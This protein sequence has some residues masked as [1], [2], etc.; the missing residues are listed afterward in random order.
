LLFEGKGVDAIPQTGRGRA[1]RKNMAEVGVAHIAPDF[2]PPHTKTVIYDV[3]DDVI[4]Y[5]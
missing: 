4:C 5:R 2:Y 3:L 1:V